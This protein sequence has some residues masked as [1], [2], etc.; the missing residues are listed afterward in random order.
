MII[1][2]RGV[3]WHGDM[4]HP[5]KTSEMSG[6]TAVLVQRFFV[7]CRSRSAS[8]GKNNNNNDDRHFQLQPKGVQTM[9]ETKQNKKRLQS[10]TRCMRMCTNFSPGPTQ[11]QPQQQRCNEG[12]LTTTKQRQKAVRQYTP[13]YLGQGV[14]TQSI[15][16]SPA[17]LVP[18]ATLYTLLTD[19]HHFHI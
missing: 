12:Q 19:G 9:R 3:A 15:P 11:N 17:S 14:W 5:P 8:S 16:F 6:T 7:D 13:P 1:C 18:A 4:K 10:N 2:A